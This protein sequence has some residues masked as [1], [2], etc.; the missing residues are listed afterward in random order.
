MFHTKKNKDLTEKISSLE[1]RVAF[2]EKL[3]ADKSNEID[4]LKTQV[5]ILQKGYE[6]IFEYFLEDKRSVEPA[7]HNRFAPKHQLHPNLDYEVQ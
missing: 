4:E 2:L 3:S 7:N 5:K 6:P 1:E